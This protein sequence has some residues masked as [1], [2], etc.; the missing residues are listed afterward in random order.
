[1]IVLITTTLQLDN[2]PALIKSSNHCSLSISVGTLISTSALG[3]LLISNLIALIPVLVLPNPVHA[4]IVAEAPAFN[5]RFM[6]SFCRSV[7]SINVSNM[8]LLRH[9][10][11]NQLIYKNIDPLDSYNRLIL[12]PY[13]QPFLLELQYST[14]H[15]QGY[16]I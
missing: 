2:I 3:F 9:L 13:P 7:L 1:M 6:Q 14:H 8:F 11:E 15:G 10:Q 12:L 16:I 4:T 5:H